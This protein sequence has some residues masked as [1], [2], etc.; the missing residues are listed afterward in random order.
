MLYYFTYMVTIS[1][2]WRGPVIVI[3]T[4]NYGDGQL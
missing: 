2:I 3:M 4:V 1:H